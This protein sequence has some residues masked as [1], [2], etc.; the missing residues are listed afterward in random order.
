VEAMVGLIVDELEWRIQ[1]ADKFLGVI[2]LCRFQTG[3]QTV[4]FQFIMLHIG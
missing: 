1:L 2:C 4:Y 3:F